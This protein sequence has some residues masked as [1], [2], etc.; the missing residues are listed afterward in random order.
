MPSYPELCALLI[1]ATKLQEELNLGL[2]NLLSSPMAAVLVSVGLLASRKSSLIF[3]LDSS[4][5]RTNYSL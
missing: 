2:V 3:W 1:A 4:S 5:H